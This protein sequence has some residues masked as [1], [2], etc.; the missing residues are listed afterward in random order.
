MDSLV[1]VLDSAV[2]RAGQSV[3]N[4]SVR[5]VRPVC[6]CCPSVR[7]RRHEGGPVFERQAAA[8]AL[9]VCVCYPLVNRL[10]KLCGAL[11]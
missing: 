5:V 8:Q 10:V 4:V 3:Y 11:S 6:F 7:A 2:E 1:Y 9:E